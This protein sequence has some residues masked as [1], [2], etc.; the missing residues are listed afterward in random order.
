MFA[1]LT[2]RCTTLRRCA[3]ARAD[4]TSAIKRR[5][6]ASGST[7]PSASPSV[8]PSTY[9]ITM[10][11][12]RLRGSSPTWYTFTMF[13]WDTAA[14]ASASRVNRARATRSSATAGKSTLT[15]TSRLS[16]SSLP[17]KTT[18]MPPS[19]MMPTSRIAG[20]SLRLSSD[21][22]G[23]SSSRPRSGSA[24]DGMY[25]GLAP[26][27]VTTGVSATS[28]SAQ[29]VARPLIGALQAGHRGSSLTFIS[30]TA[31][32]RRLAR[33]PPPAPNMFGAAGTRQTAGERATHDAYF[34]RLVHHGEEAHVPN[35]R[36]D[37]ADIPLLAPRRGLRHRLSRAA[38]VLRRIVGVPDYDRYLAHMRSRHPD[39]RPLSCEEF[40]AQRLADRYSRPGSRCC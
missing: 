25:E 33:P 32:V 24:P 31:H 6:R 19:P 3:A 14:A 27:L 36:G 15:A 12:M 35:T 10:Y 4:A 18:P 16:D 20:A 13:G 29:T 23:R 21:Q 40:T 38:E 7:R 30:F 8:G 5:T 26:E 34:W 11:G 2:S 22:S 17:M 37:V 39:A 9:C 1:G 28:Q